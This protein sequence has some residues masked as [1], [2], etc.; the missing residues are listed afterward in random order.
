[1]KYVYL[2]ESENQPNYMFFSSR[3]KAEEHANKFNKEIMENDELGDVLD[4][5]NNDFYRVVKFW[6]Y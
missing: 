1:M 6:V 4:I 2:V 5:P 3:K